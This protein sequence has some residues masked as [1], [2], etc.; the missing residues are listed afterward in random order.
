[1]P[2]IEGKKYIFVS[3]IRGK[4][5]YPSIYFQFMLKYMYSLP[6]RLEV[7]HILKTNKLKTY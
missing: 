3:Y 6:K 1:M 7:E 5:K 4:N 2:C